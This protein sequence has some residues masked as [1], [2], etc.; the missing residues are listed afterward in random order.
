MTENYLTVKKKIDNSVKKDLKKW[1]K[2]TLEEHSNNIVQTGLKD[3]N[4][5]ATAP[6]ALD[7]FFSKTFAS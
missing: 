2:P 3:T 4:D 6:T 5:E 7:P 1:G